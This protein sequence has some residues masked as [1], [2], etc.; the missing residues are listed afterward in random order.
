MALIGHIPQTQQLIH[1][2]RS[3]TERNVSHEATADLVDWM[4]QAAS[5]RVQ[6]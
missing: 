4:R 1:V 6:L 2:I 3:A 5:A